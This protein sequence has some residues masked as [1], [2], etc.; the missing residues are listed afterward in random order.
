MLPDIGEEV[1]T[2]RAFG[3]SLWQ[4]G[5]RIEPLNPECLG[6]TCVVAFSL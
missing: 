5:M 6:G 3:G 2:G 1:Q 4:A